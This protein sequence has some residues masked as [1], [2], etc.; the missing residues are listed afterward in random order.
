MLAITANIIFVFPGTSSSTFMY[1]CKLLH[2]PEEQFCWHV[3]CGYIHCTLH[4]D[5]LVSLSHL[6]LLETGAIC[7][8]PVNKNKIG[9]KHI[10]PAGW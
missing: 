8:Y 4:T 9:K 5:T 10:N 7:S 6:L 3:A 1:A 2:C